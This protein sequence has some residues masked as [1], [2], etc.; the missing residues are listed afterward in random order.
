MPVP[1]D[2]VRSDIV[3]VGAGAAGLA[4]AQIILNHGVRDLVVCYI[5]GILHPYRSDLDCARAEIA[6]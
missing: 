4:C 3:V 1:Y 6:P 5:G 2:G